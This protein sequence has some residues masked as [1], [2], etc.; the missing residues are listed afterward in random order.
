MEEF[1]Q[2]IETE[3]L[4]RK[5]IGKQVAVS[6]MVDSVCK[7]LRITPIRFEDYIN[8]SFKRGVLR[9]LE[10]HAAAGIGKKGVHKVLQKRD[11]V[12]RFRTIAIDASITIAGIPTKALVL[13]KNTS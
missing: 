4:A 5:A 7:K 9:D 2:G 8:E 3:F 13:R 6:E 10:P 1:A 11:A 12:Q